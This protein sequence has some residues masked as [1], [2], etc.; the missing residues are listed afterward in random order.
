M[1]LIVQQKFKNNVDRVVFSLWKNICFARRY[2]WTCSGPNLLPH[3]FHMYLAEYFLSRTPFTFV[4][5]LSMAI[6][7]QLHNGAIIVFDLTTIHRNQIK[8][9]PIATQFNRAVCLCTVG[10]YLYS[11]NLSNSI[12]NRV[13]IDCYA[14]APFITR[15]EHKLFLLQDQGINKQRIE[16]K[17]DF[18]WT[19]DSRLCLNFK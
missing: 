19:V 12:H 17:N 3:L 6:I 8:L 13:K 16:K 9:Q 1:I 18:K 2:L 14:W 11:K 4:Q 10:G 5:S 15:F 7:K